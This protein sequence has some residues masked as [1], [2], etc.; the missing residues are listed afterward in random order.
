MKLM[1]E[2][3][4]IF[5]IDL[6]YTYVYLKWYGTFISSWASST[7]F[8]PVRSTVTDYKENAHI[9]IRKFK[10]KF[11]FR[12]K[13]KSINTLYSDKSAHKYSDL[14]LVCKTIIVYKVLL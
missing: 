13:F 10:F 5:L 8:S 14:F 1:K 9:K 3:R 6:V 2:C 12:F 7:L 11:K 4:V